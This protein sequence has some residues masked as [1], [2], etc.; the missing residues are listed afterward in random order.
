MYEGKTGIGK[1]SR[2][3][4]LSPGRRESI[5][6]ENRKKSMRDRSGGKDRT[7][8]PAFR[9]EIVGYV[10]ADFKRTINQYYPA[11]KS[12]KVILRQLRSTGDQ[13]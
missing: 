6:G 8:A 7:T 3:V 9:F 1:D 11:Y 2:T 10:S 5:G 12:C 13:D 4:G